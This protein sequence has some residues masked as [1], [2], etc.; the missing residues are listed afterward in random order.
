M[1]GRNPSLLHSDKTPQETY[2]AMRMVLSQGQPGTEFGG[3]GMA[4]VDDQ[5]AQHG[6]NERKARAAAQAGSAP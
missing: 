2:T 4:F 3:A 5:D 1:I 6:N